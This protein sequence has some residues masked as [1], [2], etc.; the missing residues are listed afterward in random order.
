M[1]TVR[2]PMPNENEVLVT[3]TLVNQTT[4]AQSSNTLLSEPR[5]TGAG[6]YGIGS[7]QS[8]QAGTL[9]CGEERR[10]RGSQRE[11]GSGTVEGAVSAID[12]QD[13]R[14]R[15]CGCHRP[16]ICFSPTAPK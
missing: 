10:R 3:R 8:G 16:A 7:N 9:S 14:G 4:N 13:W 5:V 12:C 1:I 6:D 15:V 11:G 2:A